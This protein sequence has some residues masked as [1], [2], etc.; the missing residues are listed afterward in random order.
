MKAMKVLK[1]PKRVYITVTL[2]A[3]IKEQL[4]QWAIE[5]KRNR[6]ACIELALEQFLKGQTN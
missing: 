2:P 3:V 6:G 4:D 5:T 1:K